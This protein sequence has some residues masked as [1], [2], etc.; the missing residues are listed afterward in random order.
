MQDAPGSADTSY[1]AWVD[2]H[3]TFGLGHDVPF[4]IGNASGSLLAVVNDEVITITVP[5][6]LGF[7]AKGVDGR[8]D[9]AA[10]G[11]KGRGLWTTSGDRTPAHMETGKGT[12]PKIYNFKLRP[13]PL[14]H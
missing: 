5:Y 13:D 12:R 6:P 9:D 7:F 10:I 4:I 8:I 14:A 1:Y 3:D 2:Q 11:W